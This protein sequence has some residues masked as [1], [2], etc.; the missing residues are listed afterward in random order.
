MPRQHHHAT[1]PFRKALLFADGKNTLAES[2]L[3]FGWFSAILRNSSRWEL[4]FGTL[5][6]SVFRGPSGPP[7]SYRRYADE[8]LYWIR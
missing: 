6:V 3:C 2:R 1:L 5:L 8:Y 7:F 4:V